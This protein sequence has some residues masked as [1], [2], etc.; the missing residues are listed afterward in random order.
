MIRDLI[1]SV[2]EAKKEE[3]SIEVDKLGFDRKNKTDE[4]ILDEIK[5]GD[6]DLELSLENAF[7]DVF[8][9][10]ERKIKDGEGYISFVIEKVIAMDN[11]FYID[12]SDFEV[13]NN[14]DNFR[15]ATRNEINMITKFLEKNLRGDFTKV[16][17]DVLDLTVYFDKPY[18]VVKF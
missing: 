9:D 1:L 10:L 8:N 17:G 13:Y 3:I 14:E 4:E 16:D 6:I 11:L 2:R 5:N 18:P 15:D 12:L 7:Y